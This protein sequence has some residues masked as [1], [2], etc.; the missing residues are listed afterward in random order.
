LAKE[1]DNFGLYLVGIV[2]VVAT[3]GIIVLVLNSSVMTGDTAGMAIGK[4]SNVNVKGLYNGTLGN[5]TDD[6]ECYD[7]DGGTNLEIYG[8]ATDSD[9][10]SYS[11]EC[12]YEGY[13]NLDEAYCNSRNVA[14][15][16]PNKYCNYGDVCN[17]GYCQEADVEFYIDGDG[18]S[19]TI[20]DDHILTYSVKVYNL[21][22]TTA[23]VGRYE[24]DV[25]SNHYFTVTD[26]DH[27]TI[28]PG[29]SIYLTAEVDVSSEAEMFDA[30][31]LPGDYI[32]LE[33]S[34]DTDDMIEET[35]EGYNTNLVI[36]PTIV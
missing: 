8:T 26:F 34:L 18:S 3:V 9:E 30:Y 13:T 25:I 32:V 10:R 31:Y 7:S 23:V 17:N 15:T 22:T 27:Q 6:S 16:V 20:N 21:G 28:E 35:N 5:E 12:L 2:A 14:T 4:F 24:L 19:V 33:L 11:D 1:K 29:D 36:E